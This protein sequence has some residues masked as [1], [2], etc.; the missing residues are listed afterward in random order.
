MAEDNKRR[1]PAGHGPG[2]MGMVPEKAKNFR[3]SIGDILSYMGR[4]KF[5]VIGAMI[6]AAAGTVFQVLGP[7]IMG[8]ATTELANG[9]MRKISGTGG[10]AFDT[11]AHILLITLALYVISAVCTFTQ[12]WIMTGVTQKIVYRMRKEISEKINRMPMKYFESRPYGE[13]LSRITND[14]DTLGTGLN[15]SITSIIT[16]VATLIG[17]IVMM[18]TISPIMT[19]IAVTMIPLSAILLSFIIK[20]SQKYYVTQQS[21]LGKING[22]VEE[23]FAG[24]MVIKAFNREKKASQT[25]DQTNDVLYESAW[26][27]QFVSGI[28]MP[29]MTFVGNMGYAGVAISG[30]FLAIKGTIGIGDIQALDRKSTRL[31]SSH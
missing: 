27:S 20:L 3:K 2:G 29:V 19:L 31:N 28:M 8:H 18:L 26:K 6:F 15:Q 14:V 24:Q 12:G 10:I 30:A 17:V 7:K 25:F 16:S 1:G 9:L 22:Q 4:Y 5:A 23:N 11:I 21:Y 13:I